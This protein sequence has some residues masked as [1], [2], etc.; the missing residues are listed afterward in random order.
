MTDF[1]VLDKIGKVGYIDEQVRQEY[2]Y[3]RSIKDMR[4]FLEKNGLN[5]H[6]PIECKS[7]EVAL[8]TPNGIIMQ[9]RA[10]DNGKLGFWGGCIEDGESV[11]AGALREVKEETGLNIEQK[12][13]QYV[14]TNEHFHKYANEDIAKFLTYRFIVNFEQQPKI[15][16]DCESLGY[17]F[18]N[19][20][21]DLNRI[22]EH[23]QE[24]VQ[25]ILNEYYYCEGS[26][27]QAKVYTKR[28]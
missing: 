13:L 21:D 10:S 18:V 14:E 2:F 25:R 8:V 22:L 11:I 28:K 17:E 24:F 3:K 26:K 4:D 1:E 12:N 16:V 23:Q 15:V 20:H 7:T 27:K 6:L 19:L 9:V 5:R